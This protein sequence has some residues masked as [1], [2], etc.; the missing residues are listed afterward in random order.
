MADRDLRSIEYRRAYRAC[1][2]RRD[3]AAL[4][5]VWAS[6]PVL[7]T[8]ALSA[9]LLLLA[10]RTV[11]AQ[12]PS[13]SAASGSMAA[14]D[15]FE[16]QIRP[17][18]VSQCGDCHGAD[19][20]SGG[21][22]LSSRQRFLQGGDSGPA[23][24]P[25]DVEGSL[26]VQ[27][28]RQQGDL[29]MPPDSRLDEEQ[30]QLLERW[31]AEGATW[32]ESSAASPEGVR[33]DAAAHESGRRKG[34]DHWAFQPLRRPQVPH[35]SDAEA[36]QTPIDAF[37][38]KT[39]RERGLQASPAADRRTLMRRVTYDLTGLP[40][41]A[42]AV[43]AFITDPDPLA[44]ERLVDRLLASPQYGER[45]ARLWL[46]LAR[47]ADTKGYVS[48]PE[49]RYFSQSD[50]Y[51]DWVIDAFNRDLPYDR[52]LEL[53]IAADQM[54]IAAPGRGQPNDLAAMGFLTLGR[55]FLGVSHNIID[56]RIDT[57]TRS[58]M[59]LSVSCAR[60]HDHKYDPIPTSEYY[61]LY[62]VF[63]NSLERP[64]IAQLPAREDAAYSEFLTEL[65][66][67]QQKLRETLAEKRREASDRVR[68]RTT[69]YL[70]A[71][72]ELGRYPDEGFGQVL[73]PNDLF[74]AFVRRWSY[75]LKQAGKRQD[76]I[77]TAWHRFAALPA[78]EFST[79]SADVCREL[80]AASGDTVHP[81]VAALFVAPPT[82]MREVA[83]RYGRLFAE[84][85]A[86]TSATQD[87]AAD[88]AAPPE[89]DASR[90][91]QQQDGI[92]TPDEAALRE[93]LFSSQGPCEVP[94]E[95]FVNIA[96]Y[97]ERATREAIWTLQAD[98]DR[99]LRQSPSAHRVAVVL[100]DR[101][102]LREP[103]VFRRGNPANPGDEV[104]RRF[105]SVITGPEAPPF[106][107]GSG[108]LELA[109]HITDPDNPLTARVWV[110][111]LWMHHF[112]T[113]LVNTPSDFGVRAERPSHPELLDWLA[114]QLIAHAWNAKPLQRMIVLSAAYRQR[115]TASPEDPRAMLAQELDPDNR[116]LWRMNPR[117]LSFEEL[118]DSLLVASGDLDLQIGGLAREL[119]TTKDLNRRRTL[120]GIVD[121]QNLPGVHRV[122]DFANPDLHI[123]Q[124]SETAIPQ[125]ALFALNHPF[126]VARAR[127]AVAQTCASETRAAIARHAA[128]TLDPLSA[129]ATSADPERIR[130]LYRVILGRNP[131]SAQLA[132][133]QDFLALA[134][135]LPSTDA[136]AA[137][138]PSRDWIY[139]YGAFHPALERLEGFQ[140]LPHFDAD[141][142]RSLSGHLGGAHL[143][144][145]GGDAGNDYRWALVRR[146]TS[147][148][149]Q[150][151]RIESRL[152]H[153]AKSG[154]GLLGLIRSPRLG[155]LAGG[156]AKG[157][158]LALDVGPLSVQ[159]GDV[160]DFV[161]YC[162][163]DGDND[164]FQWAPV[165]RGSVGAD[166]SAQIV[167][168][169]AVDF[170]GPVE[171][172]LDPWQ[173]LA[174]IL[175]MSN[176]FMFVD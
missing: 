63:Q 16:Q 152:K 15:F 137:R 102:T 175:M 10:P 27:A 66:K 125:Q 120:Y 109:R 33:G 148:R 150:T 133:A 147:P 126:A 89:G 131:T 151:I 161:V 138:T 166:E 124:R 40:P 21:L 35:G 149:D 99:W 69:D 1:S 70:L 14:E 115:S 93:V 73:G 106:A 156:Q 11:S 87:P 88:G 157:Q 50:S 5:Y 174:Q 117:R 171:M 38:R 42:D 123:P 100:E 154:D 80:Q 110:N 43:D 168:D 111:R 45:W 6:S 68:S 143:T 121:R 77:F 142:W 81:R 113:G 140:E 19:E 146:W 95:P 92:A 119:F 62:G 61:G 57:L 118:R 145:Q 67:R 39:L 78:E 162:Q 86:T 48:G 107:K 41:R 114:S 8:I 13:A 108:R 3:P 90:S 129:D 82:D 139:G 83:G 71:Q 47:Y 105:L 28:V 141:G 128:A 22:D 172:P 134:P 103:H 104:P 74:P 34:A 97:F 132:K 49:E 135:P 23:V 130:R 53:Q 31:V 112:G 122:F 58:T 37:L 94:D 7:F 2:P 136:S 32:P 54:D 25:R 36:V 169:A 159:A 30:V 26:L 75:F 176:E 127:G 52:F 76:P 163:A 60:C 24:R 167:W 55:R 46:D 101:A 173:Q 155:N 20:P 4:P 17:L 18:L 165:I 98:V 44:Y 96:F 116:L 144:A 29:R 9:S 85:L 91:P 170:S 65:E 153:D 72:T 84:V 160:I 164:A 51:R 64:A 79:T 56:D 158:E 59:G 12:E